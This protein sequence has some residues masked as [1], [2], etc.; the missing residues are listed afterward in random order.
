MPGTPKIQSPL[1]W[2]M[3]QYHLT[4]YENKKLIN[5]YNTGIA[6]IPESS[7]F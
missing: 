3:F 5:D 7:T 1:A 6:A 2:D 4:V